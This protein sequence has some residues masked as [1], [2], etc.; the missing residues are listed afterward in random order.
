M[1]E[2]GYVFKCYGSHRYDPE[3]DLLLGEDV[4]EGTPWLTWRLPWQDR[5]QNAR[6]FATLIL[7]DRPYLCYEDGEDFH[8]SVQAYIRDA[9]ERMLRGEEYSHSPFMGMLEPP[10]TDSQLELRMIQLSAYPMLNTSEREEVTEPDPFEEELL[11]TFASAT[12]A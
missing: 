2:I 12:V 1:P 11:T 3:M 9:V 4:T 8:E 6:V 7:D 5:P 10:S